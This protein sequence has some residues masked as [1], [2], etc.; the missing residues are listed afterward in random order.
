MFDPWQELNARPE[1]TLEWRSLPAEFY[2]LTDGLSRIWMDPH[3]SQTERRCTIAHELAHIDLGHLNGCTS[4]EESAASQL[5]AR[6]LIPLG[7]LADALLW[8][9]DHGAISDALWVDIST[10]RARLDHL[11]PSEQHYIRGVLARRE[12]G[13]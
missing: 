10:L 9:Q 11:R 5:A 1:V 7:R 4:G 2:A 8:S 13:A 12:D 6:R 3:Q